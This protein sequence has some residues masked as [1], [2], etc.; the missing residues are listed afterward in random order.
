MTTDNFED[1]FKETDISQPEMTQEEKDYLAELVGEGKK[2]K[3]PQDLARGKAEAD[4][5]IAR[6]QQEQQ[7]LRAEL[8]KRSTIEEFMDRMNQKRKDSGT[9]PDEP[10]RG[11]PNENENNSTS[12]TQEDLDRYLERKLA[13]RES[14]SKVENNRKQVIE[15]MDRVWGM[16]S[17]VELNK[18]AQELGMTVDQLKRY[19]EDSPKAFYRLVGIENTPSQTSSGLTTPSSTV[20]LPES[21]G[22]EK[23]YGY[24]QKLRK[25]NPSHYFSAKVQNEMFQQA[26]KLG[27]KFY[28]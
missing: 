8:E 20:R 3:T 13:E 2:F 17:K 25:E 4:A 23:N 27:D 6:L 11:Q 15:T 24:Y 21:Q 16:N 1:T 18:K 10:N 7:E 5:F 12:F 14:T 26:S 22:S 19:A 28:T 9:N